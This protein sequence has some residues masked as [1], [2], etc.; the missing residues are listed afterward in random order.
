[1]R[2]LKKHGKGVRGWLEKVDLE[3]V[4]LEKVDS[5]KW[6]ELLIIP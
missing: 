4:K 6:V 1:M 5:P 2:A 3:R